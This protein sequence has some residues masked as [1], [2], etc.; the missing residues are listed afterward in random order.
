MQR[1]DETTSSGLYGGERGAG[2]KFRKPPSRKPH[3][4]PY[5]RPPP[6]QSRS[7]NGRGGGGGWFS[8]PVNLA[9]RL[10]SGG[11]TRMLP[12]FFSKSPSTD[13]L[14]TSDDQDHGEVSLL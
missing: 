11:A 3:A 7:D 4:T 2:G 6:N 13:V 8:K 1:Q 14:P 9:Y 12:Y 10:I 5:D